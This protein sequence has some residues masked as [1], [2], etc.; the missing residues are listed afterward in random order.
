[1]IRLAW[2]KVLAAAVPVLVLALV[3]PKYPQAAFARGYRGSGR[4]HQ[5][6]QGRGRGVV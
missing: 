1:M 3:L 2:W 4:D 6:R 5:H